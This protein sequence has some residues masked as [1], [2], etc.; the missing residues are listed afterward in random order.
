MDELVF[1]TKIQVFEVD[2]LTEG[3]PRIIDINKCDMD[4]IGDSTD[5][6]ITLEEGQSSRLA[7]YNPYRK[8][9]QI[10]NIESGERI[11]QIDFHSRLH[12]LPNSIILPQPQFYNGNFSLGR[13]IFLQEVPILTPVSVRGHFRLIVVTEERNTSG[14]LANFPNCIIGNSFRNRYGM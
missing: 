2:E 3:C 8:N 13:F 11:L 14:H 9:F 12:S 1:M 7:A 5:D 10:I 6:N 4:D